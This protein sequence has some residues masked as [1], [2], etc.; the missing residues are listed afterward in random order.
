MDVLQMSLSAA[1]LII[2]IVIIRGLSLHKLPKKTFLIL[3]GVVVCRLLVPFSVP[4]RFSFFT[5]VDVLKRIFSGTAGMY[6]IGMSDLSFAEQQP[7]GVASG[8]LG[9]SGLPT[10]FFSPVLIIW[11]AGMGASALFFIATYIRWLREFQTSLPAQ[12]DFIDTWLR[13]HPMRRHVQIRQ[14]D[15]IQAPLTYGVFRPVVLLPK[16]TDW[17]DEARL[18]YILTHEYVHIKRFDALTKLLLASALCV[19]WFNPLVWVM[20]VLANRDI[21]LSCDET[22]VRTHGETTRSAY[23]MTLI[24]MEEK[25]SKIAPLFNSFSK[26]AIEERITAI[27]KMKKV[28]ALGVTAALLLV[29]GTLTAFA[30]SAV[31]VNSGSALATATESGSWSGGLME[32]EQ[33]AQQRKA[34]AKAMKVY[35]PFG[36][37]YDEKT[38]ELFYQRTKV[39]DFY[40]EQAGVGQS[41][42]DGSVDLYAAYKNGKLAGINKRSQAEFDRNTAEKEA[43]EKEIAEKRKELGVPDGADFSYEDDSISNMQSTADTVSTSDTEGG[44]VDLR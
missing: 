20:Y 13:E 32:K 33:E 19:H 21:E 24:V 42:T 30:T 18:R 28:T 38:G 27:M 25:K 35:E 7:S 6:D 1:V 37:T 15:K 36:L 17:T 22:V 16:T 39:R 12:N 31:N 29:G 40:D 26:N 9:V 14:C 44:L 41:M 2:A 4:S 23:A 3:W 34:M 10:A 11:L 5:G 43:V 8:A